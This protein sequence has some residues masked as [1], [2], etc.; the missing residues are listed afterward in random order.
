MICMHACMCVYM[1]ACTYVCV[2][3]GGVSRGLYTPRT[4]SI[5]ASLCGL[6]PVQVV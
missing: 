2:Y 3:A 5:G 4:E 6:N 1:Y